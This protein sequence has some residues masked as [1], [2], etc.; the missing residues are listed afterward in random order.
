MTFTKATYHKLIGPDGQPQYGCFS[1]PFTEINH[2]DFDYRTAMDAPA[3]LWQKHFHFNQFQFIGISSQQYYLG[4]AI[5]NIRYASSAFVYLF[6]HKTKQLHSQSFLTPLSRGCTLSN[7]PGQGYS[8]YKKGKNLIEFIGAPDKH[9]YQLNVNLDNQI[10]VDCLIQEHEDFQPLCLCT[11]TGYNGWTYTQKATALKANGVI[12]WKGNNIAVESDQ[13]LG[14]YDWSC[15]YMRR[16]TA[17]N[18]ASA[19]GYSDQHKIGLNLAAGV[20]ET[21]LTENAFWVDGQLHRLSPVQFQF[22]RKQRSHNWLITTEDRMVELEFHPAGNFTEKKNVLFLATNFSQMPGHFSGS[23]TDAQGKRYVLDHVP[24][25]VE[26]H[27]AK[28]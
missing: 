16:Q 28:W 18:W 27:F 19:S 24:G 4:C 22:N 5:A 26:D 6:D 9:A 3:N 14:N 12:S 17:W 21:G 7:K 10:H 8:Y 11:K 2:K 25:V 13:F 1:T 20:N 15:G 23:L